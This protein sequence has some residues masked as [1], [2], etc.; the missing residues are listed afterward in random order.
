MYGA[1]SGLNKSELHRRFPRPEEFVNVLVDVFQE[2]RPDVVLMDGI[3]AMD[4]NGP[5]SG[6]LKDAGLLICGEDSVAVDSV[7]SYL[8][9]I[10]LLKLLTTKEAYRRGLGETELKNIDILGE[11]IGESLVK[12]FRLPESKILFW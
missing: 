5:A 3:V 2:V 11:T 8:I 7:F 12:D 9:G 6:T 4:G 10:N 1:V